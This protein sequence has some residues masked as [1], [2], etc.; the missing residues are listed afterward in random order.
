MTVTGPD[1]FEKKEVRA[2]R[3]RSV[4]QKISH[5]VVA[6]GPLVQVPDQHPWPTAILNAPTVSPRYRQ[7][8]L[9]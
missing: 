3:E 2:E 8:T 4:P 7:M 9:T 5:T 1:G 6:K